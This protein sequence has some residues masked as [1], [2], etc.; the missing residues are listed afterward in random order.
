MQSAGYEHNNL[1]T[2][3]NENIWDIASDIFYSYF[4]VLYL[5]YSQEHSFYNLTLCKYLVKF[6]NL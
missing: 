6:Y 4:C 1:Q 2:S 5:I 3:A